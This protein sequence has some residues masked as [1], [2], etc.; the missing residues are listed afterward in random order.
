MR[1]QPASILHIPI[2]T[3]GSVTDRLAASDLRGGF[4]LWPVDRFPATANL[5]ENPPPAA[6]LAGAAGG[7]VLGV[8][9]C[10]AVPSR[11]PDTPALGVGAYVMQPP[12]SWRA[13][14]DAPA[15]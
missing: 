1:S 3:D 9:L 14:G 12:P 4:V 11:A 2:V 5:P 7:V 6:Q 8:T 15:R 13:G 10:A